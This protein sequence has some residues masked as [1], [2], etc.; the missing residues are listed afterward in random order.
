VDLTREM[1]E[2]SGGHV[3]GRLARRGT[4]EDSFDN[5]VWRPQEL[6]F[7]GSDAG[8]RRAALIYTLVETER[9]GRVTSSAALRG[10]PE[11]NPACPHGRD[12]DGRTPPPP[13]PRPR[14]PES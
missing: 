14:L 6:S 8:G 1:K 9:N 12:G 3:F 7:A 13:R 4:A 11:P 2:L 5:G 10:T